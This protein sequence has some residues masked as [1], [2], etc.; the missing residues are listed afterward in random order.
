MARPE[1]V[2]IPSQPLERYRDLLGEE[3]PLYEAVAGR[4]REEFAGRA[5]WHVNSTAKGGGVA[6]ILRS[7]LPYVRGVGVDTR[8]VVP[9]EGPEFFTV[10]KRLH[11]HLHEDPGDGG[12]LGD[13]ERALYEA[14]VRASAAQLAQLIQPDDIV[15]LHDPQTAGLIPA[16]KQTGVRVIWRCHIGVDQP[17]ELAR[18]G[19]DFLRPYVEAADAYVFSRERYVW[20]GLEASKV[21][22]MPP[23]IDAFAPKNQ[24]LEPATVEAILGEIGVGA[25]V[26]AAPTFVRG[27]GS[28]GRVERRAELLQE[29]SLPAAAKLVIQVSRWDRLKDPG[30][31][32]DCFAQYI[33][34]SGVHLALI[35]PTSS[36]VADDPEGTLVYREVAEGWRRLAEE[37]RRR[38]HL[39]SLPMD[40]LDENA[41]MVNALQRRADVV[42]QKSIAE[43]FGLTVAEAMWKDK[44]VVASR[45]GGIQDQIVSGESGLLIDDP[46]DLRGFAVGIGGFLTDPALAGRIGQAARQRVKERFLA[47]GRLREYVELVASLIDGGA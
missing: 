2:Q 1:L 44:P 5:I 24:E 30:G 45:V 43:G 39:V 34:D 26:G 17:G 22:L 4:A 11:N 29:E 16:V 42:V 13:K 12:P 40:D 41:A 38:A 32:L 14:A 15:Y 37:K 25:E 20:E 47:I 36:A 19:W 3:F 6:E 27:D 10:T 28:P 35:G 8:W 23:S 18:G 7:L 46:R 33:D 9:R 21:W 31:L